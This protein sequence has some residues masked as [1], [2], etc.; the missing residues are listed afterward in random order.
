MII[1]E[2]F[3]TTKAVKNNEKKNLAAKNLE[4]STTKQNNKN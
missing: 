1:N 2:S 3:M 4:V